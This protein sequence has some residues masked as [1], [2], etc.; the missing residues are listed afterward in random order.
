MIAGTRVAL[1]FL[2][3]GCGPEA[4]QSIDVLD[5]AKALPVQ[6]AFQGLC[7]ARAAAEAGDVLGASTIFQSRTHGELHSLGDRLSTTD[8]EAAARLLEAKQRVEAAFADPAAS[9][10]AVAG[11]ISSLEAEVASAA[12]ALGQERPACGGA[13]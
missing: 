2:L 7:E 3:V 6:V 5:E 1:L 12:E 8:R 10:T 4:E 13:L 11:L 9:P